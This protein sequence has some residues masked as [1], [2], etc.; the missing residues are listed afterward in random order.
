MP[1]AQPLA[2]AGL[3]RRPRGARPAAH[4]RARARARRRGAE[5]DPARRRD[6]LLGALAARRREP[7][8][9]RRAAAARAPRRRRALAHAPARP[10]R[11]A[12]AREPLGLRL[13]RPAHRRHRRRRRLPTLVRGASQRAGGLG[14]DRLRARP[15]V[16]RGGTGTNGV[17]TAIA[18]DH[19]VQI[20][21]AEHF[22]RSIHGWT[23]SGA[24]VHDPET[25][26]VL[27]IID[28]SSG[29]RA[30]AP[31]FA[32]ARDGDRADG[33]GAA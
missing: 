7:R 20:F 29:I 5:D 12:R 24:P 32:R 2:R 23:C 1:R 18:V 17:G 9:P 8:P 21:S 13:R 16:A 27:G 25:G 31:A 22:S 28:L 6:A 10:L 11:P 26:K 4:A 3:L 15:A 19:P 33:R 14:G 30:A